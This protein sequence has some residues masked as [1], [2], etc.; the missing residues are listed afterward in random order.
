MLTLSVGFPPKRAQLYGLLK[1]GRTQFMRTHLYRE[2]RQLLTF[3]FDFFFTKTEEVDLADG[4]NISAPLRSVQFMGPRRSQVVGERVGTMLP[5][6][7]SSVAVK[8]IP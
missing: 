7:S 1:A 8:L 6:P 3:I 2:H 5:A 4:E